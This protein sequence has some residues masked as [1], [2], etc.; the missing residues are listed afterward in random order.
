VRSTSRRSGRPA[1]EPPLREL[2]EALAHQY[3]HLRNEHKRFP[4]GSTM[5]RRIEERL[6]DV[7]AHFDRVLD[8]WVADDDLRDAWRRHLHYRA[9]LPDGPAAI[10]PLAFYGVSDAGSVVEI[11][12]RNGDDLDVVVDGSLLERIAAAKD[13]GREV[14]STF[15]VDGFEFRETFTASADAL[16]ALDAFLAGGDSPPW[17][18]A[19]ELLADGLIDTHFDLTPRGRRV[20]A[21]ASL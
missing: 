14:P 19:T 6:L 15:H 1:A 9:G 8:E 20:L 3:H 21:A 18:H 12:G 11:R 17:E 10:R 7:R 5:R 16:Q 4:E 13:L 2:L